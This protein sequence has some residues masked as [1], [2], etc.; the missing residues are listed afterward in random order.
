MK[1]STLVQAS[2]PRALKTAVDALLTAGKDVYLVQ[3]LADKSWYL[4]IH[5]A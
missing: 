5:D 2:D 4:V 3:P 1:T